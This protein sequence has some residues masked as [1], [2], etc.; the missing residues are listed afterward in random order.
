[1]RT[2]PL[3]AGLSG[4]ALVAALTGCTTGSHDTTSASGSPTPTATGQPDNVCVDDVAYLQFRDDV[5]ELDLPDGCRSVVVLGDGGT[6]T[7]GPS[8]DLTVMGDGNTVNAETLRRVDASGNDNV[9]TYTG[10]EPEDLS[11]GQ[12]NTLK[13]R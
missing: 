1:M 3:A 13:A 7:I 8:D 10:D 2:A 6:A 12:G 9:I 5:T 11:D 4:L